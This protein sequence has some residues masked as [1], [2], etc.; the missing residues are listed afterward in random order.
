MTID[1]YIDLVEYTVGRI[2]EAHDLDLMTKREANIEFT[3]RTDII[4]LLAISDPDIGSPD[5]V[6]ICDACGKALEKVSK[7]IFE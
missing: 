3:A 5:F 4:Q 1:N 2:A 6:K 7:F